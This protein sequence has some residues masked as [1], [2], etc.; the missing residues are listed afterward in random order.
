MTVRTPGPTDQMA[1]NELLIRLIKAPHAP[2]ERLATHTSS[3]LSRLHAQHTMPA[4]PQQ[5]IASPPR[6]AHI[7]IG[8]PQSTPVIQQL[9]AQLACNPFPAIRTHRDRRSAVRPGDPAARGAACVQS[10][11]DN[12]FNPLPK[13]ADGDPLYTNRTHS[14]PEHVLST[15]Q[16]CDR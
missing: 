10:V 6:A 13:S 1:R 12:P 16:N 14:C 5:I 4:R 7:A 15:I 8:G 9:A 2:H 11:P 3:L